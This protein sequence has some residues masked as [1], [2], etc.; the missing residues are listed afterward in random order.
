VVK[1]SVEHLIEYLS[2]WPGVCHM[3]IGGHVPLCVVTVQK[4]L[5]YGCWEIDSIL[6]A[7]GSSSCC[8]M[9]HV[10]DSDNK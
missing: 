1:Y 10:Y 4:A 7:S 2:I 5:Y 6:L 3:P 8:C 9:Y